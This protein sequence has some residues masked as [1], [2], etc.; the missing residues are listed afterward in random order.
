MQEMG[1]MLAPT[2]QTI[3]ESESS[4]YFPTS[5]GKGI[6]IIF[7]AETRITEKVG[8]IKSGN[9]EIGKTQIDD[10][11]SEYNVLSLSKVSRYQINYTDSGW[12]K[13]MTRTINLSKPLSGTHDYRM[14][15]TYKNW[16]QYPGN[17]SLINKFKKEYGAK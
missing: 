13:V 2:Q 16:N 12:K 7:G 9:M 5:P 6:T 14:K 11:L 4:S 1:Y 10:V 3:Y 8:Y 17:N 15:R